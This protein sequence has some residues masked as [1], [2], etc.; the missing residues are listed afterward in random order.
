MGEVLV[1]KDI[2]P[3]VLE[4]VLLRSRTEMGRKI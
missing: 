3:T 2:L 1:R 4:T